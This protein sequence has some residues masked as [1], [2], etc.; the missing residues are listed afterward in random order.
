ML[1]RE[2][3]IDVGSANTLVAVEKKGILHHEPSVVAV[4]RNTRRVLAVGA[5][6]SEMLGKEPHHITTLQPIRGG[7]VHDLEGALA[8]FRFFMRQVSRSRFFKPSVL[9]N[10][11]SAA[12]K[13]ERKALSDLA[14]AAGAGEVRTLDD[15]VA[16]ALGADLPV[17]DAVGS[18]L[19]NVGAGRSSVA[20]ISLGAPVIAQV[21]DAAGDAMD[22]AIIR[23]VR[24]AHNLVVG[25][26]TAERIKRQLG[27]A[28]A[29]VTVT[30]RHLVTG[31][32][33][34]IDLHLAEIGEVFAEIFGKLE[35]TVRKVLEKTPP[36]LLSDIALHGMVLTGGG[37]LTHG[38]AQRLQAVTG[39]SVR[40]AADPA[41]AAANG[42][43]QVLEHR[44]R[45]VLALQVKR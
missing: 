25:K 35:L 39:L 32:P 3:A 10:T 16:A 2:I 28:E 18:M 13:V 7:A 36:E 19:V 23:Y 34:R 41:C 12:T 24:Q 15:L 11:S 43:L 21:T 44:V 20:V 42:A 27:L 29:P 22:E 30:G 45:G 37:A 26:R 6:A 40:I 5:Q 1:A 17:T 33:T 8:L 38:L 9:L 31:L 4:D 14:F